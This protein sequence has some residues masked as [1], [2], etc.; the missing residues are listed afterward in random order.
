MK[1]L[2]PAALIA[3]LVG[4]GAAYLISNQN[5]DAG[6]GERVRVDAVVGALHELITAQEV[7]GYILIN[8]AAEGGKCKAT[9]TPHMRAF[10]GQHLKWNFN[11]VDEA[12]L[13]NGEKVQIRFKT[14]EPTEEPQPTSMANKRFIKAKLKDIF[15]DD[16]TVEYGIWMVPPVGDPYEM[17]D[18]EL[19]II[20]TMRI[21]KFLS[22][23]QLPPI[24][25]EP[26]PS[27][28]APASNQSPSAPQKKQ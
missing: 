17:E 23:I 27:P 14:T 21:K 28:T 10:G 2:V 22:E 12:C 3:A 9:A 6:D 24:S 16:R 18:P 19:E 7:V 13:A 15:I 11:V 20:S 25:T 5:D 1:Q 26:M 4:G 8:K